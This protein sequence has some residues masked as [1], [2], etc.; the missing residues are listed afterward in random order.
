MVSTQPIHPGRGDTWEEDEMAGKSLLA[1]DY[2]T[3]DEWKSLLKTF[4]PEAI[5]H[6]LLLSSV[7]Y[8]FREEPL[9][10]ALFRRT[11]AESFEVRP[12][13]IFIVG[14]AL[15]GRS[16]KGDPINNSYS[17]E[18]DIDTLI[19]SARISSLLT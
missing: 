12:T 17:A 3:A 11:I 5:A 2:P 7:P 19:I 14:S 10:F 8:V 6:K 13:D 16:L 1:V 15:A 4:S 18:S 9:K